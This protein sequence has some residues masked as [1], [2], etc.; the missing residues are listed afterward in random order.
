VAD[1]QSSYRAG[2]TALVVA[3]PE[4]EP[5]VGRWRARYDRS[6]AAGVHAHITV[7]IPFLDMDRIDTTVLDEL[8]RM[9]AAHRTI[10]TEFRRTARW[11]SM[12][13]LP[14]EPAAPFGRLT[15]D[16]VARWPDHPPYGG[17]YADTS[18]HLTVAIHQPDSVLDRIDEDLSPRLPFSSTITHVDLVAFEGRT[19][20]RR[21]SFELGRRAKPG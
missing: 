15:A 14:P 16:V 19:W 2:M 21:H 9:F 17:R 5:V 11:P 10:D 8:T 7:L 4:A 12:L 6:A 13:Y 20:H 3:V 1:E 18:P